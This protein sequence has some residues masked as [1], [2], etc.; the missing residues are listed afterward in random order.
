ME[1]WKEQTSE[2]RESLCFLTLKPAQCHTVSEDCGWW[3]CINDV[4]ATY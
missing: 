4:E 1:R 2:A 3:G